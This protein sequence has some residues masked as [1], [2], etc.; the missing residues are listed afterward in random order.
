MCVNFDEETL[1]E[2]HQGQ[3]NI[4]THNAPYE[5]NK[6]EHEKNTVRLLQIYPKFI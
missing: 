1:K 2:R 3:L 6:T 4:D 5:P